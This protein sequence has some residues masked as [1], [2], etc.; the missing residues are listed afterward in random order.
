VRQAV[1]ALV[2][3]L[4]GGA[5]ALA[6]SRQRFVLYAARELAECSLL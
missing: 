1:Q 6:S 2:G 5:A 4:P 3:R